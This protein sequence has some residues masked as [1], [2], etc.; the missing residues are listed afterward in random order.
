[1]VTR[2]IFEGAVLLIFAALL[3]FAHPQCETDRRGLIPGD[4]TLGFLFPFYSSSADGF[5]CGT[6]ISDYQNI[7][8]LEAAIHTINNDASSATN[9]IKIGL[10]A[11]DTCNSRQ[12]AVERTMEYLG[13][14]TPTRQTNTQQCDN[15]AF[16]PSVIGHLVN[17]GP[18]VGSLLTDARVPSISYAATQASLTSDPEYSFFSRNIP[19]DDDIARVLV[20]ILKR[21][22]WS[23]IAM[24]MSDNAGERSAGETFLDVA[25]SN[26]I[27]V[28]VQSTI[29]EGTTDANVFSQILSDIG[30]KPNVKV[31]VLFTSSDLARG[32]YAA[33][34]GAN[35]AQFQWVLGH[36]AL[37]DPSSLDQFPMVTRGAFGVLPESYSPMIVFNSDFDNYFRALS[38][39]TVNTTA[40]PW[41]AEFYQGS[42]GCNIGSPSGGRP[43][44]G[45]T[46]A[47]QFV[48]SYTRNPYYQGVKEAVETATSAVR[49]MQTS[50]CPGMMGVCGQLLAATP[51]EW[52][53]TLRL[54]SVG[55]EQ[56]FRQD[57]SAANTVINI[58]H[59][60]MSG[61][62]YSLQNV[63]SWADDVL[64]YA[65]GSSDLWSG[66]ADP[67]VT[68]ACEVP[69]LDEACSS[70]STEAKK[71]YVGGDIILGGLF[72]VHSWNET[73]RLCGRVRRE[74]VLRLEA[75]L[76]ALD[77]INADGNL[78]P[79]ISLGMD[80]YDTCSNNRVAG[81][82]AQQFI[83]EA[84]FGASGSGKRTSQEGYD[85]LVYGVIG[86]ESDEEVATVNRILSFYGLPLIAYNSFSSQLSNGQ[87]FPNFAR[88]TPNSYAGTVPLARALGVRGV[89]YV[90]VLYTNAFSSARSVFTSVG[91]QNSLCVAQSISISTSTNWEDTFNKLA[92]KSEAKFIVLLAEPSLIRTFLSELSSRNLVGQYYLVGDVMFPLDEYLQNDVNIIRGLTQVGRKRPTYPP[93]FETYLV[94]L[95]PETNTRNPWF[96]EFWMDHFQCRLGSSTAAYPTACTGNEALSIEDLYDATVADV[97]DATYTMARSLHDL[98]QEKCPSSNHICADLVASEGSELFRKITRQTFT[99]PFGQELIRFNSIGDVVTNFYI[100]N[101]Q[102]SGSNLD[103]VQIAT[104]LSYAFTNTEESFIVY[105]ENG[106]PITD[107]TTQCMG[108]CDECNRIDRGLT[109]YIQGDIWI[110]GFFGISEVAND[111]YTCTGRVNTYNMQLLEAFLYTV[112]LIN[113]DN[114]ILQNFRLGAV[115]FDTCGSDEKARREVS[116]YVGGTVEYR[117]GYFPTKASVAGI[118]GGQTS[119]TSLAIAEVLNSLMVNQISYGAS[120]TELSNDEE[121]PYFLRTL[122]SDTYLASALVDLISRF[123]WFYVSVVYSD[124][125]YGND[126]YSE[127]REHARNG[128]ICVA[129]ALGV[130]A[131][132]VVNYPSIV[133]SL[134][135]NPQSKVVVLLTSAGHTKGVLEAA[136]AAEAFDL[137]WI[138]GDTWGNRQD[139][140]ANANRVARGT[141]IVDLQNTAVPAFETYFDRHSSYSNH[142][143]PWWQDYVMETFQCQISGKPYQFDTPCPVQLDFSDK[144]TQA[145]EVEYII[146]AVLAFAVG[147]DEV[148]KNLCPD[149][150]EYE[151]CD[152]IFSNPQLIHDHIKRASF[153]G[154]DGSQF[155]FTEQGDGQPRYDI[156]NLDD[157]ISF[158][159]VGTWE[160]GNLVISQDVQFYNDAAVLDSVQSNC[161][162]RCAECSQATAPRPTVIQR[163]GELQIAALFAAHNQ[164]Q[165]ISTECGSLRIDGVVDAEAMLYAINEINSDDSILAGVTLGTTTLDTCQSASRSVSELSS[166]LSGALIESHQ[167]WFQIAAVVSGGRPDLVSNTAMVSGEYQYTQISY[168][169]VNT[170]SSNLI[171]ITPSY[172]DKANALVSLLTYHSWSYV[173]ALFDGQD[174]QQRALF[175]TFLEVSYGADIC[176]GHSAAMTANNQLSIL[177]E[178]EA[179]ANLNAIVVFASAVQAKALLEIKQTL[180]ERRLTFILAF[181]Q[182]YPA[183]DI[184][185]IFAGSL[186]LFTPSPPAAFQQYFTSLDASDEGISP[187]F[188]EYLEDKYKCDID[189]NGNY[190]NP[191]PG[192][193]SASSDDVLEYGSTSS[194]VID[195][196]RAVAQGTHNLLRQ[197]C[198]DD[199]NGLCVSFLEA[200][201]NPRT[202]QDAI[203]NVSFTGVN[204]QLVTL[205]GGVRAGQFDVWNGQQNGQTTSFSRVG[206]WNRVGLMMNTDD[207]QLFDANSA[208]GPAQ[209]E[210]SPGLSCEDTCS[211]PPTTP[212]PITRGPPQ[213]MRPGPTRSPTTPDR[214]NAIPF[215]MIGSVQFYILVAIAAVGAFIAAVMIIVVISRWSNPAARGISSFLHLTLLLGILLLFI[216]V[217]INSSPV[218]ASVCA[219]QRVITGVAFGFCHVSIFLLIVRLYRIGV[220]ERRIAG[221]RASFINNGSQ[222]MIFLVFISIE[223]VFLV[224]WLVQQP[225]MEFVYSTMAGGETVA[226][227]CGHKSKDTALSLLYI[228]LLMVVSLVI[229]VQ[230]WCSIKVIFTKEFSVF[231]ATIALCLCVM[232]AW[233]IAAVL[234]DPIYGSLVSSINAI[235]Q[236]FILLFILVLPKAKLLCTGKHDE[237][238]E[239]ASVTSSEYGG[240]HRQ[241][242]DFDGIENY[243]SAASVDNEYE[244]PVNNM[245]D[246]PAFEST[247]PDKSMDL[248]RL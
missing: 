112:D 223:V 172:N 31:V 136:E 213:P 110:G 160:S 151:T 183:E 147:L 21:R 231:I 193:I 194:D 140:T 67:P 230:A 2:R 162:G 202:L 92:A 155:M 173:G 65:P 126:I 29:P 234:A 8:L 144:F 187:W 125:A 54:V 196:V 200:I 111:Q 158:N 5:S 204:G 146:N 201:A 53:E 11:W 20:D 56:V 175:N 233:I 191:C 214:T 203:A 34:D 120:S 245:H 18:A 100:Y 164:P 63:G 59:L 43:Q 150:E 192:T 185:E 61:D 103:P 117:N 225:P 154:A 81:E 28:A 127:F 82:A 44:C 123:G 94:N 153:I 85:E 88:M 73:T 87:N 199:Y 139:I 221:N 49:Q 62:G 64:T 97:V 24:V 248:A 156:I 211:V 171:S 224:Q 219:L 169:S 115:G 180:G 78:L 36:R 9:G 241:S 48:D 33:T 131:M 50:K 205:N 216:L 58:Y 17:E 52:L 184:T 72:S 227:Y 19:S 133:S 122:A 25:E 75:M 137:Q 105:N 41:F 142:R 220:R 70:V 166:F 40:D 208:P 229:A 128:G 13:D 30:A 237:F 108:V 246:N 83:I 38:P 35:A 132:G 217:P 96:A 129:M 23:Y 101:Y 195:A 102:V 159:I 12:V 79:A 74:G 7:Q 121:Y 165:D 149:L 107:P 80:G 26:G 66:V 148:I 93:A 209:S 239:S 118:I 76:Y 189:D 98:Q 1:M 228:Y 22:G 243:P 95:Q 198:G 4:I 3:P 238:W 91:R 141:L 182:E 106:Q 14:R 168:S 6:G 178:I 45:P 138:G 90:Q 57:G 235:V 236:A 167:P 170:P 207:V 179:N 77:Q 114:T 27:C 161:T 10:E 186:A 119:D 42:L 163:G 32:L 135:S 68:S 16:K 157:S 69:C 55:G 190:I 46:Q 174:R 86:P 222:A 176:I 37:L 71:V 215:S 89:Q 145:P 113:D 247:L 152:D 212:P 130:P 210:C 124:N 226:A 240:N 15:A 242:G 104:Y 84:D 51:Q 206:S 143:N 116:N 197:F 109:A 47:Q 134:M 188:V 60:E 177:Q 232:V 181:P 39:D 244:V 218:S 99:S